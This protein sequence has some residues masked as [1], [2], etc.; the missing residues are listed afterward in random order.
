M[1]KGDLPLLNKLPFKFQNYEGEEYENYK[2]FISS[3]IQMFVEHNSANISHK[4]IEKDVRD[5]IEFEKQLAMVIFILKIKKKYLL[6][7]IYLNHFIT[8]FQNM[9]TNLK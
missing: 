5:L 2:D 7:I 6:T 4:M 1:E 8:R 3:V 9:T